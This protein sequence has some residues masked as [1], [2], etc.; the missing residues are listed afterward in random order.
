METSNLVKSAIKTSGSASEDRRTA[1]RVKINS[2]VALKANLAEAL[3]AQ[4]VDLSE[5]GIGISLDAKAELSSP[6]LIEFPLLNLPLKL[7]GEVVWKKIDNGKSYCGMR[8]LQKEKYQE[9]ILKSFS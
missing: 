7:Q 9:D 2:P 4:T 8:F 1:F 5:N 3:S 6:L